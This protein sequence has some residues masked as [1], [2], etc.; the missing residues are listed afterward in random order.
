MGADLAKLES[1][2]KKYGAIESK[3]VQATAVTSA[4]SASGGH[5]VK[6]AEVIKTIKIVEVMDP[7]TVNAL[8]MSSSGFDA[9]DV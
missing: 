7:N 2:Y 4:C 6:S 1:I 3:P 8:S 9:V 5:P